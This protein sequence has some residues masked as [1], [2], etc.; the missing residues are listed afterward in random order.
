VVVQAAN[1]SKAA[2]A[3]RRSEAKRADTR[4]QP[5]NQN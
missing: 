2:R 1:T 4:M 3:A 5:L